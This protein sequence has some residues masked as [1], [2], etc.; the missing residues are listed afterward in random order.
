M[1]KFLFLAAVAALSVCGANA[2]IKVEKTFTN[3]LIIIGNLSAGSAVNVMSALNGT[4]TSRVAEHRLYCRIIGEKTTYGILVDTENRF[5]DNFEFALGTDIAKARESLGLIL[6]FMRTNPLQTSFTVTDEDE[7]TIQI[8]LKKRNVI[9]LDAIDA[10]GDII[11]NKVYLT[12]ANLE[13]GLKLL[14]AK[15][16]KKVAQAIEKNNR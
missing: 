1:K 10:K 6:E 4:P 15:A 2:Q 9:S 5:D 12:Q 16:E 11:C 13:R 14:D 3:D 7:R 8:N